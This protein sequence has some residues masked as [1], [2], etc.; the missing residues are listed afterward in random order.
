MNILSIWK[1]G[2]AV[3]K[4]LKETDIDRDPVKQ[5]QK[6]LQDAQN[7][8]CHLPEAIALATATPEGRPTARMMLL[9][10][11]DERGFVFYTNYESR[12]ADQ[13]ASNPFAAII[14]YWGELERQVRIEGRVEKISEDESTAYFQSR[15]RGS[16]IGAWASEQSSI[17]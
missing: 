2:V 14:C 3:I 5:F 16:Q 12:K 6:W 13:L 9:K 4:G 11:A 1:K 17:I 10:G 7:A 15:P 8:R